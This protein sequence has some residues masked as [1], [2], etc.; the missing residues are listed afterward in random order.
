MRKIV[1]RRYPSII[2][3]IVN[4]VAEEIAVLSIQH[5]A[6]EREHSDL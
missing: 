3:Y 1:A 5:S 4:D 6:R 2:Y